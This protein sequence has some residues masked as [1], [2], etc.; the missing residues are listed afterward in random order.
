MQA[1]IVEA[2]NKVIRTAREVQY[3]AM[4]GPQQCY[5]DAL[6]DLNNAKFDLLKVIDDY[7]PT[8]D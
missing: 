7:A 1:N 2:V 3:Q 4:E 6:E 5:E 8:K